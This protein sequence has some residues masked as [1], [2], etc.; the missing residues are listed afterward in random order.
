MNGLGG[1]DHY[2]SVK[3][4]SY[5]RRSCAGRFGE[6]DASR[7]QR[8]VTV[9]VGEIEA[10]H[11]GGWTVGNRISIRVIVCQNRNRARES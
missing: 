8:R 9:V 10:R 11:C 2:T 1:T 4:T 3:Y 7:V 6:R 5:D